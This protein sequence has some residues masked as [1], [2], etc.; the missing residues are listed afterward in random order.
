MFSGAKQRANVALTVTI[1]GIQPL[2]GSF[3]MNY[4]SVGDRSAL[5]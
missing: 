5:V 1:K 4:A 3:K 2:A